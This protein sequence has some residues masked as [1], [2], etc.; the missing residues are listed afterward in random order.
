MRTIRSIKRGL[1]L[2]RH[3]NRTARKN[4]S[5]YVAIETTVLLWAFA[6]EF[7]QCAP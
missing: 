2:I 3:V 1:L 6:T 5:M 4:V 7:Q